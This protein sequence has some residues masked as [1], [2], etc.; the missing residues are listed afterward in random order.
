MYLEFFNKY[1]LNDNKINLSK[2]G[3]EE[4]INVS[5][6]LGFYED[7]IKHEKECNDIKYLN[8]IE[9]CIKN[10]FLGTPIFVVK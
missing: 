8:K 4:T 5:P 10:D 2:Y 6:N 1:Y 9:K 3:L 7:L